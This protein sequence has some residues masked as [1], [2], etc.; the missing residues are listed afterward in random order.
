MLGELLRKRDRTERRVQSKQPQ[1]KTKLFLVAVQEDAEDGKPVIVNC[2]SANVESRTS[3]SRAI[4]FT[5]SVGSSTNGYAVANQQS[6]GK[7]L[8][9]IIKKGSSLS[10]HR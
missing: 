7:Y 5:Q 8:K 6:D 1:R 10:R 3:R 9:P 4:T 2:E